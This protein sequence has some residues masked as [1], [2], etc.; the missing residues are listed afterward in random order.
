MDM[1]NF[2]LAREDYSSCMIKLFQYGRSMVTNGDYHKWNGR[3]VSGV[4]YH[5]LY[6]NVSG[7]AAFSINN[8]EYKMK[9]GY[10]YFIPKDT[11]Q[12]FTITSETMEQYWLHFDVE[13][14]YLEQDEKN[15]IPICVSCDR[16]T[17]IS[18]FESIIKLKSGNG[19]DVL[20][21]CIGAAALF[22]YYLSCAESSG[23]T[24]SII[25]D[26]RQG[27][28]MKF[29][30]ENY[31]NKITSQEI[32]AH[33]H[34]NHAY[35]IRYFKKTFKTTPTEFINR[36]RVDRAMLLLSKTDDSVASIAAKC[37]FE[38][39]SYFARLFKKHVNKTPLEYRASP[40]K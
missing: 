14:S 31:K 38:S 19:N 23:K 40:Q 27:E 39:Y 9:P 12:T 18:L 37:G 10:L 28:I 2:G 5:K 17:V 36:Y 32:S 33:L 16:K 11:Y 34:L 4:T 15:D 24:E 6:Y 1:Y 22:D 3:Q 20:K 8:V 25:A 30:R 29:I 7:E 21:K 35:F 26:K 13:T